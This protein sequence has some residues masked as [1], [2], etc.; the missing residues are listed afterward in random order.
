MTSESPPPTIEM[1]RIGRAHGLDGS[2]YV[3]QPVER[4]LAL[5]VPVTVAG[6]QRAIVRRSGTVQRPILRLD[7]MER[8]EDA[9]ALRGQALL[10]E[11]EQAPALEP[12]EYWS[13]DLEGCAVCDQNGQLGTVTRLIELPSCEALEVRLTGGGELLVPMVRDAIRAIDLASR[14]IE[15]DTTF[16]GET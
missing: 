11:P 8:R 14:R 6:R 16:L 12:Q 15:V 9:E 10:L 5:R 7:G 1:G 13:H 4:L 2:F 3:T